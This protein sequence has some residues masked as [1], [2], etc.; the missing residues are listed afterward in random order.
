MAGREEQKKNG[1][2]PLSP[3]IFRR[4]FWHAPMEVTNWKRES[5]LV[6]AYDTLLLYSLKC[7]E[8]SQ[9]I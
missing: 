6:A 8:L 9:V 4:K 7:G 2:N 3:A 5:G 1:D